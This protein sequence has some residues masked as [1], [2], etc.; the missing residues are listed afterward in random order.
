MFCQRE[1]AGK[2]I[3]AGGDYV[4]RVKDNQPGLEVDIQAG[5]AFE[6]AAQDVATAVSL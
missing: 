1:L 6:A 3:D 5:F 4:W 2:V